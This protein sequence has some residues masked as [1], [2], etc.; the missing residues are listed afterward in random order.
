MERKTKRKDGV[1]G[2][3]NAS[4]MP[5]LQARGSFRGDDTGLDVC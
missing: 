4:A 1:S 2:V 3:T 5:G